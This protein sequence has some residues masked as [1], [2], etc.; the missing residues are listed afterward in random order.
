MS[1]PVTVKICGI[2]SPEAM[3]AAAQAGATYGGLVFHEKSPRNL[4]VARARELARRMRGKLKIVN[5]LADPTDEMLAHV[6]SEVAPD[7]LQLHGSEPARRVAYLRAKFNI[8][9][10]KALPVADASD[11]AAVSEYEDVADLLMF[12]AKAPKG[13]ARPGGH[14]AAFDWTLLAGR[15]FNKPWFLAGGLDPEN[16]ARAIAL[17]GA[18]MVDV[19]SGVES[20]PGVKDPA[21]IA[22][23][24]NAVRYPAPLSK[25]SA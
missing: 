7:F 13:A 24:I 9:I 2:T 16:V 19:S 6:V 18:E 10:I 20:A 5:L 8:P 1:T 22:S 15:K 21:R 11:L 3:D 12:D 14:G 4:D 25:Q 23:F 17:S